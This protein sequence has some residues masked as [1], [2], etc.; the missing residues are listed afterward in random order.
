LEVRAIENIKNLEP[1]LCIEGLGNPAEVVV[2]EQ[3]RIEVYQAWPSQD[4]SPRITPEVETLRFGA[5]SRIAIRRVKR[6]GWRS[7]YREALGGFDVVGGIS[8]IGRGI[9]TRAG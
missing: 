1:K 7:R 8:W 3:I 6:V 5:L 4:V 2:L 9:T